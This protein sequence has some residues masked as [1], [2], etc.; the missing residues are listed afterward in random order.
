MEDHHFTVLE[1]IKT[2]AVSSVPLMVTC[3]IRGGNKVSQS[4]ADGSLDSGAQE[5]ELQIGRTKQ[6]ATSAGPSLLLS[7]SQGGLQ[8]HS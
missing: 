4:I 8:T 1:V 6:P 5:D 2:M 7:G 3:H